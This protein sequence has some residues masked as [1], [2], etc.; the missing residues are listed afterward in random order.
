MKN[1]VDGL[2]HLLIVDRAQMV[3]S[4]FISHVPPLGIFGGILAAV[5]RPLSFSYE[6]LGL[7]GHV[8]VQ[9]GILG[10]KI[11]LS[12]MSRLISSFIHGWSLF[13]FIG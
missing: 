5:P 2:G 7:R 3:C 1:I 10:A 12:I 4:S 11:L 6:L 9:R 8:G 13:A